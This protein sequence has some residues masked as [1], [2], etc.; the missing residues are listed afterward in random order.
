MS[1]PHH[2]STSMLVSLPLYI[3]RLT[4]IIFKGSVRSAP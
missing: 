3:R 1:A 2:Y 4:W